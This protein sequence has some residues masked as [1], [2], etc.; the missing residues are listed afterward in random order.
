MSHLAIMIIT[1]GN[2]TEVIFIIFMCKQTVRRGRFSKA[3]HSKKRGR[4]IL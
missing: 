1:L 2:D 4:L 3:L